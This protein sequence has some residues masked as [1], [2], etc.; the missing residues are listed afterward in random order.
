MKRSVHRSDPD[1]TQA[2][3]SAESAILSSLVTKPLGPL[4]RQWR[5]SQGRLILEGRVDSD[6]ARREI[7]A[8]ADELETALGTFGPF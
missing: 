3:V 8:R 1:S 5:G 7:D 4:T 6:L 2:G